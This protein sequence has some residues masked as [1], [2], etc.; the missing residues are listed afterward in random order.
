MSCSTCAYIVCVTLR[1]RHVL[2]TKIS[3]SRRMFA[4]PHCH[5]CFFISVSH[6]ILLIVY[7][8]LANLKIKKKPKKETEPEA[9]GKYVAQFRPFQ[10][11]VC[12]CECD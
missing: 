12:V 8:Q 10:H 7:W 2:Q 5:T 9:S 11:S 6:L 1:I 3:P 4:F